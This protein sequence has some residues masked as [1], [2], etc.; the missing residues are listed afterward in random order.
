[1]YRIILYVFIGSANISEHLQCA[2]YDA[3]SFRFNSEPS[4]SSQAAGMLCWDLVSLPFN[5]VSR[6]SLHG[7]PYMSV[8]YSSM[9]RENTEF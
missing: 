3:G 6:R 9:L 5:R 1:M 8:L 7:H 4:H 2:R